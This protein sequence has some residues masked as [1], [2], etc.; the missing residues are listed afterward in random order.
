[1]AGGG[2]RAKASQ[3]PATWALTYSPSWRIGQWHLGHPYCGGTPGLVTYC[4]FTASSADTRRAGPSLSKAPSS[5]LHI[6]EAV[7][8]LSTQSLQVSTIC[9]YDGVSLR[10]NL[11]TTVLVLKILKILGIQQYLQVQLFPKVI[12]QDH[13]LFVA[14]VD[15]SM[16]YMIFQLERQPEQHCYTN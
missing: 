6:G 3:G 14:L 9:G 12:L 11:E 13:Q 7:I 16:Q 15:C 4:C 1:M 10:E 8:T 2:G 5:K